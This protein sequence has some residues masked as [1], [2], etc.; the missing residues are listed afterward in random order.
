M[1]VCVGGE[2]F[3]ECFCNIMCGCGD[4]SLLELL[5]CRS[6]MCVTLVGVSML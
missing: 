3:V 1:S 4:F 5:C 6:K 2:L